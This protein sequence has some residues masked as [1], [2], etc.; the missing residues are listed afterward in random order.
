[1]LPI[2]AE[3]YM[4]EHHKFII[5]FFLSSLKLFSVRNHVINKRA[6]VARVYTYIRRATHYKYMPIY[7]V[8]TA[9]VMYTLRRKP[10]LYYV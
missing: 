8:G 4:Y 3:K 5:T 10:Y 7:V 2:K 6:Q 1:M 9:Y